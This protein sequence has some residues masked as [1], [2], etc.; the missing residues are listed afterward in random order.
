MDNI[1][2]LRE[3]KKTYYMG[4][5]ATEALRGIDLEIKRG[6]FVSITGPSG[7]GKST[8]LHILGLLDSSTGG[9]MVL[10]GRDISKLDDS[11]RADLRLKH[12]GFVFQ[13]FNL[14]YEMTALENVMLPLMMVDNSNGNLQSRAKQLLEE[15]GLKERIEHKPSELSGGQ[16]QRVAIARSLINNPEILL[17]D[18]P[19]GNLDSQTTAE[20]LELLKELNRKGQTIVFVTHEDFL[21]KK[22]KRKVRIVDGKVVQDN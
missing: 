10:N 22:A 3:L 20:I 21:A 11:Q 19:T 9:K 1:I 8:L 18:E 16:Q 7:A 12:I 5:V 15:V 6:D 14:F 13:F 4:K 17:A 2:E